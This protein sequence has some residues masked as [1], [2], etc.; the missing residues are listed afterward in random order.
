MERVREEEQQGEQPALTPWVRSEA[1]EEEEEDAQ[2]VTEKCSA[3]AGP[4]KYRGCGT[5]NHPSGAAEEVHPDTAEP[6]REGDLLPKRQ[7]SSGTER[8]SIGGTALNFVQQKTTLASQAHQVWRIL[9][10]PNPTQRRLQE[11]LL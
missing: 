11:H 1:E 5:A 6:I 10:P 3:S 7:L 2:R 9:H 8:F 4:R